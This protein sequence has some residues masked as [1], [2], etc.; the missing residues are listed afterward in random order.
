MTRRAAHL[1]ASSTTA[2]PASLHT[3]LVFSPLSWPGRGTWH[4]GFLH[5]K[6]DALLMT[7]IFMACMS[8]MMYHGKSILP[9]CKLQL[10]RAVSP[11][12]IITVEYLGVAAVVGKARSTI[13]HQPF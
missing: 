9:T 3:T 13:L 1:P 2:P 11:D 10:S 6:R 7:H 4:D 8:C 12:C 5:M